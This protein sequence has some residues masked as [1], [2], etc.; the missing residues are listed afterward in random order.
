ML[1]PSYSA[2]FWRRQNLGAYGVG[3][4][5]LG[6]CPWRLTSSRKSKHEEADNPASAFGGLVGETK[7]SMEQDA[8][9]KQTR[10]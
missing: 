5:D 9:L 6:D 10:N 2:M 3:R 4:G 1:P 7:L 8:H